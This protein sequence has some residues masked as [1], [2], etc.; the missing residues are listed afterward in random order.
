MFSHQVI[1]WFETEVSALS[2]VSAEISTEAL[3]DFTCASNLSGKNL[4]SNKQ[5]QLL[6]ACRSCYV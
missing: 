2:S 1:G 4:S 6:S 5:S 3:W